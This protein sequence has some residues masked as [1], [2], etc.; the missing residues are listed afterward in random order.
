MN[1]IIA[2]ITDTALLSPSTE[3]QI[4]EG[5]E[6]LVTLKKKPRLGEIVMVKKD[7]IVLFRQFKKT[8]RK[9]VLAALNTDF[10]DI[11][12]DSSVEL[13]GVA[14]TTKAGIDSVYL[15]NLYSSLNDAQK[16]IFQSVMEDF[17]SKKMEGLSQ[18]DLQKYTNNIIEKIKLAA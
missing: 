14:N 17:S 16:D 11:G 4:N 3:V 1:M 13:I 2:K 8:G 6:V 7:N 12:I 9:K 5:M 18:E 15:L 10:E